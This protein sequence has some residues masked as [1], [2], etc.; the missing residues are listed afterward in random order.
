VAEISNA[1]PK[2]PLKSSSTLLR[3]TSSEELRGKKRRV[4]ASPQPC[5]DC[6]AELTLQEGCAACHS[7]GYSKCAL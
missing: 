3:S 4:Y 2:E 1:A 7:C 6:S 5:P